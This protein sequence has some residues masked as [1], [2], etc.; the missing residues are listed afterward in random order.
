MEIAAIA[1]RSIGEYSVVYAE[2]GI[3]PMLGYGNTILVYEADFS[4]QS[5]FPQW[6][7]VVTEV[8]G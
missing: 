1:V 8:H 7:R 3:R 5:I 2:N 4:A 6:A